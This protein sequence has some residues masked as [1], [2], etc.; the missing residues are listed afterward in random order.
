MMANWLGYSFQVK[1]ILDWTFQFTL[2]IR[3][4][5]SVIIN[6]IIFKVRLLAME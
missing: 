1:I 3:G 4:I 5:F 6:K 2:L